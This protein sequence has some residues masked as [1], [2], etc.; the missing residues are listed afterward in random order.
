[1]SEIPPGAIC[2]YCKH[3]YHQHSLDKCVVPG[4]LCSR[5]RLE[6]WNQFVIDPAGPMTSAQVEEWAEN[7][8]EDYDANIDNYAA[9]W[10]ATGFHDDC[11][12]R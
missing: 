12:D 10:G 6:S 5:E 3:F 8:P 7:A 11:G 9:Y 4:C 1:M 2:V